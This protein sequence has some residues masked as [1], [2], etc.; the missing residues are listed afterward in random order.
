M[1]K[2]TDQELTEAAHEADAALLEQLD[3]E[4]EED[5]SEHTFSPRFNR[6]MNELCPNID[7]VTGEAHSEA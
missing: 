4:M 7:P 1:S 3:Q 5:E 6:M 2:F